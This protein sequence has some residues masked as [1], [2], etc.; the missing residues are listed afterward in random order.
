MRIS[1]KLFFEYMTCP[2]AYDFMNKGISKKSMSF[3]KLVY[4]VVKSL[5]MFT[6]DGT[7]T[8]INTLKRKWD[9]IAESNQLEPK[10]VLEGWGGII[11]AHNY[12][13][14]NNLT[15]T[16]VLENYEVEI[17][18][19]KISIVG[20]LD[21]YKDKG[22]HIEIFISHFGKKQP[23]RVTIDKNLKHTIDSYVLHKKYKK[24]V[25]IKYYCF[26]TGNT[27]ISIRNSRDYERMEYIIKNVG[28]ALNQNIIY[29]RETFMCNSCDYIELCSKWGCD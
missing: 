3:N 4:S 12:V 11:N 28:Q 8:G 27:F 14:D 22:D 20:Q 21:P 23:D 17:P 5:Y 19:S 2:V 26:T 29:P 9:K 6:L 10:K 15:F 24:D 25:I 16:S 7:Y 13:V 18:G 1:E